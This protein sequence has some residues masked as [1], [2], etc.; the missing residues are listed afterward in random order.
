MT[1]CSYP[2]EINGTNWILVNQTTVEGSTVVYSCSNDKTITMARICL[3][4]GK[5]DEQ[6]NHLNCTMS[7]NEQVNFTTVET[8]WVVIPFVIL[9]ILATVCVTYNYSLWQQ[10]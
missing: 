2:E 7:K 1:H 8:Y 5:W 9:C 10:G 3:P 4:E 6:T